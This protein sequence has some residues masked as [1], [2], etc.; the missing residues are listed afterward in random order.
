MARLGM[1][2]NCFFS[3]RDIIAAGAAVEYFLQCMMSA[4]VFPESMLCYNVLFFFLHL[5]QL[6]ESLLLTYLFIPRLTL[7]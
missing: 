2:A 6:H 1:C 7:Y 4:Q 5:E 3:M